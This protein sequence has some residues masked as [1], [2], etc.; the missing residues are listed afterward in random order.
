MGHHYAFQGTQ[1]C[2]WHQAP[3]RGDSA[4]ESDRGSQKRARG[5]HTQ[6]QRRLFHIQASRPLSSSTRWCCS[7]SSESQQPNGCLAPALNKCRRS[8]KW[9]FCVSQKGYRWSETAGTGPELGGQEK[10]ETSKNRRSW[11]GQVSGDTIMS[12]QSGR[13]DVKLL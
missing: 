4:N 2:R 13:D 11:H 6:H 12:G 5:T 8:W 7:Q 3:S 1:A 10:G 9:A